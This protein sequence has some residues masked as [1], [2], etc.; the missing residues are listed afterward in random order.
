MIILTV[1]TLGI[2]KN[3][4]KRELNILKRDPMKIQYSKFENSKLGFTESIHER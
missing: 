2:L 1:E 4:F 3:Y